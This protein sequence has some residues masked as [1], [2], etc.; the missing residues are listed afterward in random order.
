MQRHF[1]RIGLAVAVAVVEPREPDDFCHRDSS[2]LR[3]VG[4]AGSM[5]SRTLLGFGCRID[6]CH[7]LTDERRPGRACREHQHVVNVARHS[8]RHTTD[9][10]VERRRSGRAAGPNPRSQNGPS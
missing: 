5:Y 9:R 7:D 4:S 10:R 3:C 1:A 8:T 6:D 2:V